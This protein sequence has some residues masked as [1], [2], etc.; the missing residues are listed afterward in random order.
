MALRPCAECGALISTEAEA[1]P[2]CGAKPR[3]TMGP[4][5]RVVLGVIALSVG[6]SVFSSRGEDKP[7]EKT[8]PIAKTPEQIEAEEAEKSRA[9]RA[10]FVV[11][12][13]RDGLRDPDSVKWESVSVSDDAS[14]VCVEY[15][16]KNGFGGVNFEQTLY[17]KGKFSTSAKLW[18][19]YCAGKQLND[20]KPIVKY[21]L[22]RSS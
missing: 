11:T 8:A 3:A 17:T 18:N 2:R 13:L 22:K 20:L 21:V 16:A 12:A 15:R 14:L 5:G 4:I 7:V 6:I 1:C 19:R 10:I 9:Q